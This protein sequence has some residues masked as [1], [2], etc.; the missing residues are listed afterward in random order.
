[1]S[2]LTSGFIE[3]ELHKDFFFEYYE[4]LSE[5]QGHFY[6]MLI[7]TYHT[8]LTIYIFF[9]VVV[10]LSQLSFKWKK[11]ACLNLKA[12]FLFF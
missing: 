11:T 12:W 4:E 3:L 1:M 9:V 5:R 6:E 7:D 10:K 8:K 2:Y